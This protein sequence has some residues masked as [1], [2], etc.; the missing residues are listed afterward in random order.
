MSSNKTG[1]IKIEQQ[2]LALL[3][4]V[5]DLKLQNK[6]LNERLRAYTQINTGQISLINKLVDKVPFG[7]VM[8]D[9]QS[10]V[11]H[12]NIAAGKILDTDCK[13]MIGSHSELYFKDYDITKK[14]WVHNG[15]DEI[16]M[17]SLECTQTD[18]FLMHSAFLSDEG[19][20]NIVVESFVD[21][22]DIKKAEEELI[23]LAKT[24]DEFLGIL[25][26]ELRTPLNAI[27]GY[28]SLLEEELALLSDENSTMYLRKIKNAGDTLL[29]IVNDI[30]E[31]S[32]LTAG[33]IKVDN[34]PIDISMVISQLEFR[35][36]EDFFTNNN[37]LVIESDITDLF[38]VDLV[39]LMKVLYKLL[40]NADKFS[41]YSKIIL[42]IYK[43]EINNSEWLI[44]KVSDSGCGIDENTIKLIF[45]A[46]QQADS[47]LS[48]SF[49]GL[50]LGLSMVE[51]IVAL[52][53][54]RIE[55]ESRL[56]VGSTF[57]VSLPFIQPE[58]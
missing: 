2:V 22:T 5:E 3:Q 53:Q 14:D 31:F 13:N 41:E 50:G 43:E 6:D 4:E 25:S 10:L 47:S 19:S 17:Q 24:K 37:K 44:F 23:K 48:R 54:G 11:V 40:D 33:K 29:N 26:H 9:E 21:I 7:I 27:H 34:I 30:L 45:Q 55:V 46:F 32:D 12:A 8:L 15:Y 16:T 57:K 28:G 36:T 38:E 35:F 20:E 39:L 58:L 18:K 52:M 49:E 42:S 1:K 51:K 56:G